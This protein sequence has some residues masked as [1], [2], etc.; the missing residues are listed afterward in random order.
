MA[1]HG[2][3]RLPIDLE[4]KIFEMVVTS[5]MSSKASTPRDYP[6]AEALV[7]ML[8]AWRVKHW[9]EPFIHRVIC[10]S[11][12]AD[13]QCIMRA[14]GFPSIWVEPLLDRIHTK[15]PSFFRYTTHIF[16]ENWASE[17]KAFGTVVDACPSV[18]TL[19]FNPARGDPENLPILNRMQSLTRLAFT[20]VLFPD[21]PID[22]SQP[23]FR[24]LTH[25]EVAQNWSPAVSAHIG[26]HLALL[27]NLTH[28]AFWSD[29]IDIPVNS[30]IVENTRLKCIVWIIAD[31]I[32][33]KGIPETHPSA[34]DDRFV[35]VRV[36]NLRR[37]WFRGAAGR[38]DHWQLAEEFIAKKRRGEIGR[39]QYC[40]VD[41][42]DPG[43]NL[44]C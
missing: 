27:P 4:R 2:P 13:T 19:F 43:W 22:F 32:A 14:E 38:R 8:V 40:T 29:H 7:C 24:N 10:L 36:K 23:L 25:L 5:P 15:G 12:L 42:D 1:G 35:M 41:P 6:P 16:L 9:V 31:A 37:A 3:P 33:R 30:Q 28:F 21:G 39:E 11:R 34:E 17:T 26:G 44:R 20:S 18:H